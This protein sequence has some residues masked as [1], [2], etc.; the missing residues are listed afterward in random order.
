MEQKKRVAKPIWWKHVGIRERH[1]MSE[2]GQKEDNTTNRAAWR[3]KFISYTSR[4]WPSC[5]HTIITCKRVHHV[6]MYVLYVV[7]YFANKHTVKPHTFRGTVNYYTLIQ[8]RRSL[9]TQL[10]TFV[11]NDSEKV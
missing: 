8:I 7:T 2:A 11:Y 4:H 10:Y 3:N 6:P 5:L 9:H 1:S